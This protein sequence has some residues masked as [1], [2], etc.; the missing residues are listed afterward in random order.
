LLLSDNIFNHKFTKN[1]SK[2][3][4]YKILIKISS[5]HL[6]E[7]EQQIEKKKTKTQQ[8]NENLI[9]ITTKIQH[10]Y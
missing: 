8:N 10:I 5:T 7:I 4:K 3:N 1:Y 2:W 6:I 9:S